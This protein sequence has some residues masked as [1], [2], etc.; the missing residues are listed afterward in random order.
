MRSTTISTQSV[1]GQPSVK[2]P[3]SMPRQ[4]G[5][6]P[7]ATISSASAMNEAQSDGA[8]YPKSV[9]SGSLVQTMALELAA[10]NTPWIGPVSLGDVPSLPIL[11]NETRYEP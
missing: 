1:A 10:A 3:D 2:P 11:D 5:V 8:R 6:R 9:N 7:S 4:N